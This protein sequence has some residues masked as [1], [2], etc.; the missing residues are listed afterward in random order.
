MKLLKGTPMLSRAA[1]LIGSI[2]V[3]LSLAAKVS[4]QQVSRT[5][6]SESLLKEANQTCL[7]KIISN[8]AATHCI[9]TILTTENTGAVSPKLIMSFATAL[10]VHNL[11]KGIKEADLPICLRSKKSASK[12]HSSTSIPLDANS[13]A[14]M[15][16]RKVREA[17]QNHELIK[18]EDW[19]REFFEA[20]EMV[21][22]YCNLTRS[23]LRF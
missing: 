18:H 5:K 16:F 14:M 10:S 3:Q 17:S 22:G 11:S 15:V 6:S 9:H 7:Q 20:I 12:L 2:L 8:D 21:Y 1:I 19:F 4:N 23:A 13:Y